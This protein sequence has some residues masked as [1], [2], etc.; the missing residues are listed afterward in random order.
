MPGWDLFTE[1][2][3]WHWAGR[4]WCQEKQ[5]SYSLS[6]RSRASR[7]LRFQALDPEGSGCHGHI[8]LS[9]IVP[10]IT[11]FLQLALSSEENLFGKMWI[12]VCWRYQTL[13]CTPDSPWKERGSST[14]SLTSCLHP[15]MQRN[16]ENLITEL[17]QYSEVS[18]WHYMD[19][20]RGK[21][22]SVNPIQ[23]ASSL[24]EAE[25]FTKELTFPRHKL[26]LMQ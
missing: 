5:A 3:L 17:C 25:K 26:L 11:A 10:K 21:S 13:W 7:L 16:W 6:A 18:P 9:H 20:V 2:Q 22:Y 15:S 23:P 19:N 8:Y 1:L 24:V 4:C 12:S 14:W